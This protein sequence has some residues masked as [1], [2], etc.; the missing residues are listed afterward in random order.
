MA[1]IGVAELYASYLN[2]LWLTTCDI[3]HTR[4]IFCAKDFLKS[5]PASRPN[6]TKKELKDGYKIVSGCQR[7]RLLMTARLGGLGARRRGSIG[8]LS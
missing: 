1:E 5:R 3:A 8:F 6:S 7:P 2:G 4:S